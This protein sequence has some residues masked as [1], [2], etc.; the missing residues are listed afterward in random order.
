MPPPHADP[1]LALAVTELP[2]RPEAR[3]PLKT[4]REGKKSLP[5][6]PAETTRGIE[7][8][9][10]VAGKYI[11]ERGLGRGGL[12]IVVLALHSELGHRVAI[13]FLR[14]EVLDNAPLVERFRREAQIASTLETEHVAR[15]YD[16]GTHPVSGPYIVME[17]LE[18]Q[19]L[20]ALVAGGALPV[21]VAV[22]YVVQACHAISQ[23]HE[24]GIVH[25]DIKP[26]NLFL[27]RRGSRPSIVKVLDFGF[28]KI[29]SIEGQCTTLRRLTMQGERFG[30]P[31]FMSP[32][33]I[34]GTGDVDGRSDIW[35][36][37]VVLFELLTRTLPFEG[38]TEIALAGNIFRAPPK[39]LRALCPDAPPGLEAVIERCLAKDPADRYQDVASLV[40]DLER[41][42]GFRET[43]SLVH[44]KPPASCPPAADRRRLVAPL[45]ALGLFAA[46]M[47]TAIAAWPRPTTAP[48]IRVAREVHVIE[49]HPASVGQRQRSASAPPA[50]AVKRVS[51]AAPRESRAEAP[52]AGP[53]LP[54]EDWDIRS[55]R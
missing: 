3:A 44:G 49:G 46:A 19:D 17:F 27:A 53:A 20:A 50:S 14:R 8:G 32:E 13:K 26:E 47:A 1:N 7:P 34:V 51:A 38:Q 22:D 48:A 54:P 21:D 11:V 40:L 12:G 55:A 5:R 10:T 39:S 36:L 45:G 9:E 6:A 25:R 2:T 29:S 31:M 23:A 30:T 43:G 37:G 35:A 15:V 41:H 24:A 16:V 28:C 33:Q 42:R 4:V 18:G 52:P